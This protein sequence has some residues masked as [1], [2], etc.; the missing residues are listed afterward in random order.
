[1]KTNFLFSFG[2]GLKNKIVA[3]EKTTCFHFR[4]MKTNFIFSFR[5]G[6]KDKI[7]PLE[8]TTYSISI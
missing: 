7:V 3:L 2:T 6:W 8:K 1:M 5:T 4:L